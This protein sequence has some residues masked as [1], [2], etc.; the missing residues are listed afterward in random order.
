M[1]APGGGYQQRALPVSYR[2]EMGEVRRRIGYLERR[3]NATAQVGPDRPAASGSRSHS[4]VIAAYDSA[5]SDQAVADFVTDGSA[6]DLATIMDAIAYGSSSWGGSMRMC[7]GSYFTDDSIIVPEAFNIE[8]DGYTTWIYTVGG[9]TT[10]IFN[11]DPD[12]FGA[13]IANL[14]MDGFGDAEDGIYADA[15]SADLI[16]EGL[17]I[18]GTTRYA[19]ALDQVG[20]FDHNDYR[21]REC[22]L[23]A[24]QAA[25]YVEQSNRGWISNNRIESAVGVYLQGGGQGT[26]IKGNVIDASSYGMNLVSAGAAG[27]HG[28]WIEGV[29]ASTVAVQLTGTSSLNHVADNRIARCL[30]GVKMD[31]STSDNF[32]TDNDLRDST[33]PMTDTGTGNIKVHNPGDDI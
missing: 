6:D 8:G 5:D 20:S 27:I 23:H 25:V 1:T 15:A 21:I 29:T 11:L 19:I 14:G 30:K 16:F 4:V 22:W 9:H 13:R 7:S 18:F 32:V 31:A 24:A 26:Q 3:I 17:F 33:T 28:N 2:A 12:P 10:P